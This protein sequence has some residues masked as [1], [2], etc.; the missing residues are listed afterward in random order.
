[1]MTAPV[2]GWNGFGHRAV[3]KIACLEITDGQQKA[4]FDLLKNHP[5]FVAIKDFP[6]SG[7]S[8][9][10]FKLRRPA[11]VS[12]V[13]WAILQSAT[14][15]DFVRTPKFSKLT[16]EQAAAHPV[17]QYHRRFDHFFDI[18]LVDP[19]YK[20]KIKQ[21]NPGSLLEA[22]D[23]AEAD[24]KFAN[25]PLDKKAI[26]FCWLVHLIGDIHQ[27]LHCTSYYSKD[28]PNGDAGGNAFLIG[29]TNL[30]S[31]WDEVLGTEKS[32]F[33]HFDAVA[34]GIHR[35]PQLQRDKM[36]ELTQNTTYRS[37][38]AESNEIAASFAY[39][40]GTNALKGGHAK[41]DHDDGPLVIPDFPAHYKADARSIAE[42]RVALAAFRLAAKI[43]A[44]F[45]K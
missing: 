13:E 11:G 33:T 29:K 15:P 17:Y 44:I 23:N 43:N 20:V 27:P 2:H 36:V 16:K 6:K 7:D 28:F 24:L 42:R 3:A 22:L 37:W 10:F 30:H 18:P 4:I 31:F 45:P 19:K 9:E 21:D 12:E 25:T 39:K 34:H 40:D 8:T 38:A 35:A 14:W 26:A 1:M 5:H 41:Q 32:S